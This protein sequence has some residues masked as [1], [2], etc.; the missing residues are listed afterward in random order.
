[1]N[2]VIVLV[3]FILVFLH[4]NVDAQ[5]PTSR[6]EGL[7]MLRGCATRPTTLNCNEDTA[8]YLIKLYNRGDRGLL[9]P[10]LEAGLTSDGALSEVLGDFYSEVLAKRPRSFLSSLRL[11]SQGQQT[12]FCWMAGLADGGGLNAATLRR[13]RSSL[14]AFSSSND[15]LAPIARV[16]LMEVDRANSGR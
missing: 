13:V 3:P 10:L 16:C 15:G 5:I 11:R 2:R 4:L 12:H 9:R 8:G 14:R 7:K 1:M 6:A